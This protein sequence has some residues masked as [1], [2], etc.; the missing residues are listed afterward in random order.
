MTPGQT[1][2][3]EQVKRVARQGSAVEILH[4]IEPS[5]DEPR[6]RIELS[7]YCGDMERVETGLPLRG[8]E[9]VM[10]SV[11]ANFPYDYPS[12]HVPHR[13]FAGFAHVMW[14]YWLCL[15]QAP[16]TEWSPRRG[17]FGFLERLELWFRQ[18]ALDQLDPTGGPLHPPITYFASGPL[19]I[20]RCDAPVRD[21]KLWLGLARLRQVSANRVDIVG[22]GTTADPDEGLVGPAIL[23]DRSMPLEYPSK[24]GSLL[25]CLLERG[26]SLASVFGIIR[27]AL[28]HNAK[29]QPL[30]VVL[31]APM[32]GIRE[33]ELRQHLTGWRADS[34]VGDV[35]GLLGRIRE[36]EFRARESGVAGVEDDAAI[37]RIA[38]IELF[39]RWAD[40]TGVTWCQVREDRPEVTTRRDS[41]RP[42]S[43]FRGRTVEVWGCGAIGGYMAEWI[44]RAGARKVLLRD[45]GVVTPGVL[46]RQP[47]V[48]GDIGRPKAEA[49]AERL[50][51][52]RDDCK[53]EA[54]AGDVVRRPLGEGQ[55]GEHVDFVIDATASNIVLAKMEEVWCHCPDSRTTVVSVA[56]DRNA[57]RMMVALATSKHTG[58]PLDVVR[59]MKLTACRS[60]RLRAYVD[61]FFPDPPPRPF[62]PEPGC[63]D[64]TFVGSGADAALLSAAAVNAIS[65]MLQNNSGASAHGCFLASAGASGGGPAHAMC[66]FEA[67]LVFIDPGSGYETRV[68]QAA[69]RSLL[70]CT[71]ASARRLGSEVETGGL[72]FGELDEHLKVIWVSE[73]SGPPPD[74]RQ[75]AEEFICG[76][77]GTHALNA[78]K[79]ERSRKS[80]Q[81]VGMWHTHAGARAVPSD[82]DLSAMDTL[83]TTSPAP[84]ER[85]LLMIVG[86]REP[87]PEVSASVFLRREFE[88]LRQSGWLTR[89]MELHVVPRDAPP[90]P[91]RVGVA[92]SGGGSRAIA[93]HL[94]CLRALHDRQ[95]LVQTEVLSTVSGG[96]VI[97]ALYAYSDYPFEDFEKRVRSLLR[98]GLVEAIARRTFLSPRILSIIGT[99]VI[100]GTAAGAAFALRSLVGGLERFLPRRS[101]AGGTWA[102]QFQPPLRRWVSRT[103]AFEHALRDELYGSMRLSDRGRSGLDIVINA[104]ELRTGTA[105][106]FGSRESGCWRYGL[107]VDNN[108]DVATAVAASAA[109]PALLPA[110]DRVFEFQ[111]RGEGRTKER[112]ILTDGGVYEN[113]GV[114]C[115]TPGR[116]AA[117]STN[118]FSPEYIICCDAGPGQFSDTPIPYGW[119]TRMARSFE[120]THRQVQHG[121]QQQLHGWQEQGLV[122]GFVYSYL[123][124]QDERLPYRPPDLVS[125]DD[126]FHYPTDFSPMSEFD[127]ETLCRRGEQLTSLLVEHYCPAL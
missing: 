52:I 41:G 113:L 75:S 83:L 95:V 80:A 87:M 32:R 86:F 51:K 45:Q 22:W 28:E 19:M 73:A 35:A 62:Q 10:V 119:A 37:L 64:A 38:V 84:V 120:V 4:V 99:K 106:R 58:G 112:I 18:A 114:T 7:I 46:V 89:V 33:G 57:E 43:V 104:C 82:R 29:D 74:S 110:I 111:R 8:R 123:G 117:F 94:G 108:V 90:R 63:S 92:L 6:L 60:G 2:A 47:Y 97:G 101:R 125:R 53:V 65:E 91:H 102:Q 79:S 25:R 9:R 39:E 118:V 21:G 98:R 36:L 72:L 81:Y 121:L 23:L 107:I 71:R 14:S 17:M 13:R 85:L 49:L 3:L 42:A 12:V 59:R 50:G 93:F 27:S 88:S 68:E 16:Q 109:Y 48:D 78:E 5:D 96:S 69:W 44:V 24:L 115:M 15:Y 20:P 77:A 40:E 100:S 61:A 30:Y 31:G 122:S 55:F 105:F 126:V 67:D 1:L 70:A 103:S 56:I 66:S 34:F 54:V 26:V 124:Q 11:G 116:D 76:I 127:I